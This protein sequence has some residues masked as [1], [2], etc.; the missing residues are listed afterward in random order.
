MDG[1][2]RLGMTM[3]WA[4]EAQQKDTCNPEASGEG[5]VLLVR[6]D[7]QVWLVSQPSVLNRNPHLW[8]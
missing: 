1:D 2:A 5:Q 4:V 6:R 3:G 7:G 8:V